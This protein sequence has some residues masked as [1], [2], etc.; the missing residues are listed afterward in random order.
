MMSVKLID[1]LIL[2]NSKW[3]NIEYDFSGHSKNCTLNDH[4]YYLVINNYF[5]L[6]SFNSL[7]FSG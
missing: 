5:M 4:I 6:I 1:Q 2:A 3:K 7:L